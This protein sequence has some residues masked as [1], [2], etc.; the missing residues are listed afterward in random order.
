M[1]ALKESKGT[2]SGFHPTSKRDDGSRAYVLDC[3]TEVDDRSAPAI[4]HFFPG[5]AFTEKE[6][7]GLEGDHRGVEL[8][9]LQKCDPLSFQVLGADGEVVFSFSGVE[10]KG[11]PKL[12]IN[13]LGDGTLFFSV[14][15]KI[16]RDEATTLFEYL[17]ADAFF[18]ADVEQP[19]L[20]LGD[21]TEVAD[22]KQT[23]V[24]GPTGADVFELRK[25]VGWSR[26]DLADRL[27]GD[28]WVV[29]EK[30]LLAIEEKGERHPVIEPAYE[31]L[32]V[33]IEED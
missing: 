14:L 11:K 28:G 2:I 13:S 6:I 23:D 10:F 25:G 30:L 24:E 16:R 33:E 4:E 19:A 15:V 1:F 27:N 8:Q 21:P 7:A 17:D 20:P 12:R 18:V 26:K 29:D 31:M 9:S 5:Y 3:R 32:S 22:E